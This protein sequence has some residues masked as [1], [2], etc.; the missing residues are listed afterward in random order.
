ER[1]FGKRQRL[2]FERHGGL[3]LAKTTG[4]TAPT[5]R[6]QR[7]SGS[8]P[9][10]SLRFD[11]DGDVGEYLYWPALGHPH[12]GRIEL[13]APAGDCDRVHVGMRLDCALAVAAGREVRAVIH[14][15]MRS[16]TS[17]TIFTGSVAT[18]TSTTGVEETRG[19]HAATMFNT[20]E[21]RG[22]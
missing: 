12:A 19:R 21:A 11:C 17:S 13:R 14:V 15:V 4:V 9:A 8:F 18:T 7:S 1:I 3:Q 10:A 20:K 2:Q 16:T 6:G 22:M 5:Y